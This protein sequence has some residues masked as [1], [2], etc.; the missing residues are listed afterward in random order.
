MAASQWHWQSKDTSGCIQSQ[1][2]P[3]PQ[4]AS[5][6][7]R[8]AMLG[9]GGPAA[10]Q[11]RTSH[12]AAEAPQRAHRL[13]H[14]CRSTQQHSVL[15]H[16]LGVQLWV[17]AAYNPR[18]DCLQLPSCPRTDCKLA[19]PPPGSSVAR[20]YC[21][22]QDCLRCQPVAEVSP[23]TLPPAVSPSR[24]HPTCPT[25]RPTHSPIPT[26]QPSPHR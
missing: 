5:S 26:R 23:D 15:T 4:P 21:S 25:L 17:T 3:Q 11:V 2:I 14:P 10:H 6:T 16:P 12:A 7:T 1:P 24:H 8:R 13:Q 20:I 9:P 18:V 19:G 22:S